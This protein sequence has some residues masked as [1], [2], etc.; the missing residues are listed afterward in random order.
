MSDP[1]RTKLPIQRPPFDGT[2]AKT[3]DGSVPDWGLIGHV[4]PAG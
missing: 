1:D 3:L 2:A 4:E